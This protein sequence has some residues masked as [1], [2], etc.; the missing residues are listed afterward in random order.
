MGAVCTPS[1]AH[2]HAHWDF[3]GR[4]GF[5]A[6]W[7]MAPP[8]H[9]GGGPRGSRRPSGVRGRSLPS[10]PIRKVLWALA[11]HTTSTAGGTITIP[12]PAAARQR[13]ISEAYRTDCAG[14]LGAPGPGTSRLCAVMGRLVMSALDSSGRGWHLGHVSPSLVYKV[15]SK[16]LN[17]PESPGI[18][19]VP[20]PTLLSFPGARG[21]PCQVPEVP[22]SFLWAARAVLPPPQCPPALLP[23]ASL[24]AASSGKAS[25]ML[26]PFT[27][28]R[29][30]PRPLL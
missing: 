3:S 21:Q 14:L 2:A 13:V 12:G 24:G 26:R 29:I 17:F 6:P 10:S 16:L 28:G 27:P 4:A 25:L 7:R 20:T 19:P 30:A 23:S 15:K 9:L 5:A 11:S 8:G 18:G 22:G 1:A